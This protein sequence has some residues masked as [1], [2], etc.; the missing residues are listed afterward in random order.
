M[1]HVATRRA[2]RRYDVI[3]VGG[4]PAGIFAAL[5]LCA[6]SDLRVLLLEKGADI[7]E[8]RCP[9]R[10]DRLLLALRAPA[11]SPLVGAEP[12]AFSDGKL[13]LGSEVGGWLG[14]YMDADRPAALIQD[15]DEV[16]LEFGAPDRLY[17]DEPESST[18]GRTWLATGPPAGALARC[19]TWGPNARRWCWLPC[20][21][22]W[23]TRWT[24]RPT[25]RWLG[26]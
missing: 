18:V 10:V 3:I 6:P 2:D 14:E 13:T 8:R 5:E 16:Y 20:G 7:S 11:T 17:G 1:R 9:A 4:G 25:P 23:K 12:G 21:P 15:V 26:S 19:G 24:S 22:N